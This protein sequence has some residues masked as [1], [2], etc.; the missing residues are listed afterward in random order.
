MSLSLKCNQHTFDALEM[1]KNRF[2]ISSLSGNLKNPI[3]S[4]FGPT[5][6][7]CVHNGTQQFMFDFDAML[8]VMPP[9]LHFGELGSGLNR[10]STIYE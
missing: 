4:P 7:L 3:C 10:M 1:R 9:K 6:P 8:L 5:R 2:F